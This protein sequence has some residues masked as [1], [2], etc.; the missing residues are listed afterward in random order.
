MTSGLRGGLAHWGSD[1][2]ERVEIMTS[3]GIRLAKNGELG[4]LESVIFVCEA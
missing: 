1:H 4:D 3:T 2:Q